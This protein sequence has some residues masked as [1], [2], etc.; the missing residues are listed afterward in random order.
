MKPPT[1]PN[2]DISRIHVPQVPTSPVPGEKKRLAA[3]KLTSSKNPTP[4]QLKVFASDP[5]IETER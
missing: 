2:A 1:T 5:L 4:G 3:I